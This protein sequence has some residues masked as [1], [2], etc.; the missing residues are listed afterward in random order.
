MRCQSKYNSTKKLTS[1]FK[2]SFSC[3]SSRERE[4][5][6]DLFSRPYN[7]QKETHETMGACET[8]GGRKK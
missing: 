8:K 1:C 5:E 6:S 3:G 2:R 7:R 4:F